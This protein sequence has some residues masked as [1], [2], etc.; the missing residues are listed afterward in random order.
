MLTV[1][2]NN[3]N[4]NYPFQHSWSDSGMTLHGLQ[5]SKEEKFSHKWFFEDQEPHS[6]KMVKV[7][8]SQMSVCSQGGA[9]PTRGL[10]HPAWSGYPIKGWA[11]WGYPHWAGWFSHWNNTKVPQISFITLQIQTFKWLSSLYLPF[12]GHTQRSLPV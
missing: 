7:L 1:V 2:K 10:L 11:G 5:W 8:F 4:Y 12:I 3:Y 6:E 9:H